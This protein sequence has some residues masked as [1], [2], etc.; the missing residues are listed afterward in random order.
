[1]KFTILG[2]FVIAIGSYLASI[3]EL[4]VWGFVIVGVGGLIVAIGQRRDSRDDATKLEQKLGEIRLEIASAKETAS[5]TEETKKLDDIGKE[6][7]DWAAG[8]VRNKERGKLEVAQIQTSA[9]ESQLDRSEVWRPVLEFFM[10][11]V[12]RSVQAYAAETGAAA[13]VQLPPLPVNLFQ[14]K[15]SYEGIV[16]FN[17]DV[18]WRI[19]LQATP[20]KLLELPVLWIFLERGSEQTRLAHVMSLDRAD[21]FVILELYGDVLPRLSGIEGKFPF[22]NYR[23]G[24]AQ[25]IRRLVEAQ[26]LSL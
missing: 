16:V 11:T 13:S 18:S 3:N 14:S 23:I 21:Q 4:R 17:R 22:G 20:S 7:R 15:D 2:L 6:F 26:L 12:R 24:L 10:E 25:A 1:M 9:V 5:S 8:F 19:R